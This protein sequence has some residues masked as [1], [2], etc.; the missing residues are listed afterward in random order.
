MNTGLKQL[1]MTILFILS[2]EIGIGLIEF[3]SIF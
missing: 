3:P 1:S 2:Q